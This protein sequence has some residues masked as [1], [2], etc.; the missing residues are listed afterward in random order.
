[1][2]NTTEI[3]VPFDIKDVEVTDTQANEAGQLIITARSTIE[4]VCCH[5]CGKEATKFYGH[6]DE[7]TIRHTESFGLEIYIRFYPK[8]Y[9]CPH[10]GST[11][12][13][14]LSCCEPY[15]HHTI[16]YENHVLLQLVNNT[17]AD[18]AIKENLTVEETQGIIDR[19]IDK[20]VNWDLIEMIVLLG[21][22]EISRKKGH[23]DFVTIVTARIDGKTTIL[24]VLKD[25]TRKTVEKFLKTIPKRLRKT[26]K[27]V[28]S[29]MYDGFV[30]AA[31]AVLKVKVVVD[32]F[33]V[34]KLYRKSLDS[35]RKSEMKRLKE[36]LPEIEYKKLKNVMWTLRKNPNDLDSEEKVVLILLFRHS[37]MLKLAYQ[38]CND[39]TGIFNQDIC[40][41]TAKRKIK[42][43]KRRVKNSDLTCFDSFLSTLTKFEKEILNYFDERNTS[44]FVEG[45]NNKIKVIKRR[46]YGI[47]NTGHWFQRIYLDMEGYSLFI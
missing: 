34:A 14:Q 4:S 5:N 45:L 37:P 43:W 20:K 13:Q 26:I 35:L 38:L 7:R 46:C 31:K 12:T 10:C 39:L 29:D 21:L 17:V 36:E 22:D 30:N 28:C 1:M 9:E 27:A 42:A 25:R 2:A 8:R 18:I 23:K 33:H 15:C 3:M 19:H 40:K 11:T 41:S 32:R 6:A 44:G 47:L 24:A 16:A